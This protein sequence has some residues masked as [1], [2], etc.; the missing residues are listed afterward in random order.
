M[1]PCPRRAETGL[2][3]GDPNEDHFSSSDDT[4]SY[5]GSLNPD[6]LMSKIE[7]K[8]VEIDPTDKEYKIYVRGEGL[9]QSYR[10]CP[11]NSVCKDPK[12][13][14]HWVTR[15]HTMKK[16]YFQHFSIEQRKKF[17]EMMKTNSI[18]MSHPFY[19]LPFFVRRVAR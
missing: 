15:P 6:V 4:C 9:T 1:L 16:F 12:E 3:Y 8:E 2:I 10:D 13:C 5:C 11:V 7:S 18:K 14:S 17:V 19:V